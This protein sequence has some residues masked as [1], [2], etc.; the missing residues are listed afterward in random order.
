VLFEPLGIASATLEADAS[1]IFVGSSYLYAN[2][3]DWLSIARLLLD[4]GKV[5]DKQLLS[6][7]FVRLMQTPATASQGRYGSAQ[8]WL[9][10]AGIQA[11]TE[12]IPA[13]AFWMSGHDG[14]S[15][16]IVPSM[17]LAIIRLGLTPSRTGYKVPELQA[18]I[19]KALQ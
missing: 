18:A 1:G 13:D 2:A 8:T 11:G 16:I 14:Q 15:L 19:I 17:N 10:S 4:K 3:R 7:D 12:G 9:Q 6:E 5:G